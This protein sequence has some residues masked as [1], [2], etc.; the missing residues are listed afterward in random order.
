MSIVNANNR[1]Q[2]AKVSVDRVY[3]L[4]DEKSEITDIK[5]FIQLNK[6]NIE[7]IEFN[8][9]SFSYTSHERK[10]EYVLKTLNLVF[11][12]DS[13][14]ALVGN[15]GCGKSTIINLLYRLWDVDSGN[16]LIDGNNIKSV[17]LN[18]LRKHISIVTQ[19][20]V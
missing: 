14:W 13:V 11:R 4:L 7:K 18:S 3:S 19:Q 17:N 15:S 12:K 5:Y 2:Q 16:I 6:D 9:V 10:D 8:N 1:I 20:T